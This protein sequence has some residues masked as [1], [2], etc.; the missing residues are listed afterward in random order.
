M[1]FGGGHAFEF[2]GVR[3]SSE[4]VMFLSSEKFGEVR[5][6]SRR[7]SKCRHGVKI[8]KAVLCKNMKTSRKYNIGNS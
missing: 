3:R 1:N 6:R 5:R 4:E 2:G 8:K 7:I